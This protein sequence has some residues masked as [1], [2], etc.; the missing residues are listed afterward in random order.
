MKEEPCP[1]CG[2]PRSSVGSCLGAPVYAHEAGGYACAQALKAQRDELQR[3]LERAEKTVAKLAQTELGLH[4][5][6]EIG[7]LP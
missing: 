2:T 6:N 5:L 3:R 1:M 7:D 4:I